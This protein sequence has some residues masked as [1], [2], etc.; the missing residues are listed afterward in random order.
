MWVTKPLKLFVASCQTSLHHL[1]L[2]YSP[3]DAHLRGTWNGRGGVERGVLPDVRHANNPGSSMKNHLNHTTLSN[4]VLA[5]SVVKLDENVHFYVEN[6]FLKSS[7][8]SSK[9][10]LFRIHWF[11]EG[12][13][14]LNGLLCFPTKVI[15]RR[16]KEPLASFSSDSLVIT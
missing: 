11:S 3:I 12:T 10:E 9:S 4:E 16:I 8:N 2:S 5:T 15:A 1:H 7:L 14:M 13:L 6:N